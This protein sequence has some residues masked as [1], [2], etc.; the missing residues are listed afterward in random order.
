MTQYFSNIRTWAALLIAGA[1]FAACSSDDD[2][3]TP[4]PSPN[5][6]GNE[7][8]YT[9][10]I[11]ASKGSDATTRALEIGRNSDDTK[12]VLNAYWG[13]SDVVKVINKSTETLLGGSL[14]AKTTGS[15]TA[16][17]QG[18]I[19][20]SVATGN[21][22]YLVFP[23]TNFSFQGQDGTLSKIA[24]TY[25][26][27]Y[28][29]AT[30]TSVSGNDIT[31]TGSGEGG[32]VNFTNMQAIV[33][34][35]L[36]DQSGNA[37]N[38]TSLNIKATQTVS[39]T[40]VNTLVTSLNLSGASPT[41]TTGE[42]T[43]TCAQD[44]GQDANVVYA[45][46]CGINGSDV[47]LTATVGDNTYTYTKTGVTFTNGKYYEITVKMSRTRALG[48]LYYSDGTC[49]ATLEAGKTPIG[50][51]AYLD[52]P[53]TTNDDEITEKSQG[54]GHGLV[55]CLRNAAL[56]VAW[57]TEKVSKFTGQ[58]VTSVEDLKRTTNVS[59]YTNTATLTV[60]AT[61]ADLYPAAKAAKNYTTLSAPTS[62]TGWFLPSAQQW[63]KMMKGLGG[64]SEGD[65]TWNSNWFDN[66]H[67]FATAW[68]N[69][70]A[71]AGSDQYDSVIP[72]L[73][74]WSSSEYNYNY[75]VHLDIDARGTGAGYSL[76]W[77]YWNKGDTYYVR[78]VLAF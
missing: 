68:E 29:V 34:F 10:T 64:L 53:N 38:P 33:R 75:A 28:G 63:V 46:L 39:G 20:G 6:E 37:I 45:A 31:A 27:S 58:E 61:T 78:P 73:H 32:V 16:T 22:L 49:S 15:A 67:S 60:D 41:P 3:L 51:I 9:M 74:Y 47:T 76:Y 5:G 4:T 23:N 12:N 40:A 70:Q 36:Q 14:T 26:Y 35:T 66:N 55:L 25:D 62:T 21:I 17:L 59:G 72:F 43:I 50:V 7:Q 57:S 69:A 2:S 24:S 30:V 11:Q 77:R 48:D 44:E 18:E 65:I 8:V 71:K 1:A 42:L 56:G 54:A 13:A 19:T 52:D